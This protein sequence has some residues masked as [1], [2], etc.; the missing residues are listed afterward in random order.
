M[1]RRLVVEADGAS[2]GNPGEASYGAVV[3]DA[4]TGELLAEL[5]EYLGVT[6][7]NVA[8]YNGL[9]AGLRAAYRI[10]PAARV[11]VRMDSKLVVEQM[12]GRWQIKHPDL[13]P[14]AVAARGAF[15]AP[16]RLSFTWV[17]RERNK[18][19]DRLA[20]EALDARTGMDA[21][22]A[23][24]AEAVAPHGVPTA[25]SAPLARPEL[26]A[27]TTLLL[28]RHGMTALS[29]ERRFSGIGDPELSPA[30]HA[31][32]AA[33]AARVAAISTATK[34][35]VATVVSSP[36]TRARQTARAA[37]DALGLAVRIEDDLRETDFGSWE[38]LT[39]AEARAHTP[40]AFERWLVDSSAAPPGGESFDAVAER[41]LRA[42]D[43]IV[44]R[45]PHET[46]LIV[47]HVTPIK[48]LV[49]AVL[50]APAASLHRMLLDTASL[51]TV[52]YFADDGASLRLFNDTAHLT[53]S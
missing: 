53:S 2:R 50:G 18:H 32:V 13:R 9:V 41:V 46:V 8:E 6:T 24:P 33:L 27:P 15:P 4:D 3:R 1:A 28:A 23:P 34:G 7:N 45:H 30:G 14:L 38:G 16:E 44:A 12:S 43:R 5:A 25:H 35:G 10:D 47:S 40:E 31:Q 20:N 29:P 39:F 22:P 36:A 48:T 21:R 42:R 37:A 26:G 11:E 19:A 49:R 52:A 51:S 17:P